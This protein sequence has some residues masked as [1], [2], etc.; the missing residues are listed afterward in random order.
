MPTQR[1]NRDG[2]VIWDS[3]DDERSLLAEDGR[4]YWLRSPPTPPLLRP[5]GFRKSGKDRETLDLF[6]DPANPT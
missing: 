3:W 1:K 6:G 4:P 2:Q 5:G